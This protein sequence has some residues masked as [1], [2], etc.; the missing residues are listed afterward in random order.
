A[1]DR[2]GLTESMLADAWRPNAQEMRD[3]V[4]G[5]LVTRIPLGDEFFAKF[6]APYAVTHRADIHGVFL[7][8]CE[9]SN[10]ISLENNQGGDDLEEGGEPAAVPLQAGGRPQG[11]PPTGW[12]GM[13][14]RTREKTAGDAP[15][16]VSGHIA[17][18]AVLKREDVPDDLWKPDVILWAG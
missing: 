12:D 13:W 11:G 3:A 7:R 17:Y 2:I 4:T 6:Q 18:R 8:A 9:Q 16:R 15:P 1:L 5:E 14:S 10:L